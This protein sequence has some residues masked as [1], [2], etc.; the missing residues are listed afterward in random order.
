MANLENFFKA[1]LFM[2]QLLLLHR[3]IFLNFNYLISLVAIFL[4]SKPNDYVYTNVK[5]HLK[6][7]D[8]SYGLL[9]CKMARF[10]YKGKSKLYGG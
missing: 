8:K 4:N 2:L 5:I 6:R 10:N 9:Y 1:F 3:I 7:K